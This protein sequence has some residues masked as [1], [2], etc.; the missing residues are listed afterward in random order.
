MGWDN[1]IFN[2]NGK[3]EK[4]L[5]KTLELVFIQASGDYNWSYEDNDR[6]GASGWY[7]DEDK[8][9]VLCWTKSNHTDYNRFPTKLNAAQCAAMVYKW[10]NSSERLTIKADDKCNWDIDAYHSGSNS[11]GWRVYCDG[12]GHVGD[13]HYGMIAIRPVYLWHGK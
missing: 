3:S 6:T 2:I 9:F 12:W 8:G 13:D 4:M 1:R 5:A 7:I 10:L 11:K